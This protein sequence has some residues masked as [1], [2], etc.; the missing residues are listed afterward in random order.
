MITNLNRPFPFTPS[1]WRRIVSS[2][3]LVTAF[4]VIVGAIVSS[5]QQ[6]VAASAGS[7]L[8]QPSKI[9]PWVMQHTA[10][11]QQAQFI[12]VLADQANLDGAANFPTKIEKGRFVFQ[13]LSSKA[14]ATQ[15]AIL[16]WMREHGLEHQAFYIVNAVVVKGTREVA[17]ALAA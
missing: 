16:Q 14:Q 13:T 12:V 5:R 17:E 9:A 8:A 15:G 2:L 4:I 1:R 7:A 11:G 3:L 10:N 6:A